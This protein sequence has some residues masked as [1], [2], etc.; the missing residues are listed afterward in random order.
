MLTSGEI[1][2]CEYQKGMTGSFF[3]GLF[4]LMEIADGDNMERLQ[5]AYPEH[6][7]A[8]QRYRHEPGY[9]EALEKRYLDRHKKKDA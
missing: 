2:L 8:F 5:K 7:K 1:K 3:T 4:K 6:A 9:W